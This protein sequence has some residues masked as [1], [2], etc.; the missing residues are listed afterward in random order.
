MG[1]VWY[2]YLIEIY[3][4]SKDEIRTCIQ[5]PNIM[6][7]KRNKENMNVVLRSTVISRLLY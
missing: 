3:V 2:N 5:N 6:K 1:L 7:F 4:S